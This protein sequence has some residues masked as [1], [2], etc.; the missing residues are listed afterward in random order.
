M[1]SELLLTD[2]RVNS[3]HHTIEA[4]HD[5]TGVTLYSH[6]ST[7]DGDRAIR[8][9]IGRTDALRLAVYLLDHFGDDP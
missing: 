3:A 1:V 5:A 9:S 2:V 7:G 6:L 8:M 4:N